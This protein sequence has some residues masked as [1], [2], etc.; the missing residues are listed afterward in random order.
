MPS[1]FEGSLRF[2][3][4]LFL[5]GVSDFFA[6]IGGANKWYSFDIFGRAQ[7]R[8]AKLVSYFKWI[9]QSVISSPHFFRFTPCKR[10]LLSIYSHVAVLRSHIIWV[11][12]LTGCVLVNML[13]ALCALT[14]L[15]PLCKA[16]WVKEMESKYSLFPFLLIFNSNKTIVK[17]L[18]HIWLL[19]NQG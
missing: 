8:D 3:C 6:H 2:F 17:F 19:F 1:Y 7:K 4:H 9:K 18:Y 10:N 5:F 13:V 11:N 14:A 12:L 16:V 15:L